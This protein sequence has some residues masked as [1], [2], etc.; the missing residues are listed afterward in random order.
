MSVCKSCHNEM[1]IV[2]NCDRPRPLYRPFSRDVRIAILVFTINENFS[3][4]ESIK[5]YYNLG[6]S[7]R[8]PKTTF[9]KLG[10]QH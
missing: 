9:V 10:T 4:F 1:I 7:I 2:V 5:I 6:K 8:Y 3:L